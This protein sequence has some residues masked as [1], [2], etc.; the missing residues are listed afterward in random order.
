M[1]RKGRRAKT[2]TVLNPVN[3]AAKLGEH[4]KFSIL[5]LFKIRI[6]LMVNMLKFGRDP[7]CCNLF[8]T[9]FECNTRAWTALPTQYL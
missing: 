6:A 8:L 4:A 7:G 3:Q 1:G 5:N 2:K 9:S